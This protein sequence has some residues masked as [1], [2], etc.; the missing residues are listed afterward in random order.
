MLKEGENVK[1]SVGFK[2]LSEIDKL[3]Y[4]AIKTNCIEN[5]EII[6][7]KRKKGKLAI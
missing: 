2:N 5:N 4:E 6:P 3:L 7:T 1:D